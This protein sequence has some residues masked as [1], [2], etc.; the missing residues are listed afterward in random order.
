[1]EGLIFSLLSLVSLGT[2]W[3]L[4]SRSTK[5]ISPI[6]SSLL[7]QLVG[8]PAL[9]FI[10]PFIP[11]DLSIDSIWPILL[12]GV[13]ESF[14]MLILFYAMKIGDTG[15][16]L[17]ITD[18]YAVITTILGVIF[19][20]DEFSRFMALG[21]I[22]LI[23]GITLISVNITKKLTVKSGVIPALISAVGTGIY[24]FFIGLALE[25]SNWF[26]MALFIRI[27]ISITLTIIL[28]LKKLDIKSEI[29]NVEW[30]YIISG[31][32]LDVIGF[33]FYNIAV[34]SSTVSYSTIMISAQS[35]IIV[36]LSYFFIKEKIT[37]KQW[38]GVIIALFG[39]IVIQL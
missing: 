7:I 37:I 6:L 16:V 13:Y 17:P 27:S 5:T 39:L 14:V 31:A 35:L 9:L 28:L 19:L 23:T 3:F 2:G 33:S 15:V 1:M 18:G 21:F 29:K 12:I 11:L 36:I 20:Q 34:T 22:L 24:F 30:K 25:N 26:T 38:I 10:I 4:I 32:I 8:I